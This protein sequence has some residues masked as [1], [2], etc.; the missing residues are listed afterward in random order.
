MIEV[1]IKKAIKAGN[2]SAVILPRAWLNKDVRVEL[3]KKTP[4][5]MLSDIINI[6]K[7]YISLKDIIGIYLTGSYARGEEEENSDIDI[8]VV[9]KG[10]DREMVK[11]GF[12]N[13]MIIS[14]ELL[15]QKLNLD[16]FPVG[17]MIKEAK[18]LINSDYL[19]S[20]QVKITKN[21]IK[22]YLDTTGEKLRIIKEIISRIEKKNKK[23]LSDKVAYTLVLR[24]RTLYIIKKLI[25]NAEYSKKDFVKIIKSISKGVNAYERYLAVKNNL[26]EENG[27]SIE[28]AGRLYEYLKNQLIEVKKLSK[29]LD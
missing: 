11:E 28:E 5:I 16:I 12:Y 20:I 9:T 10:I 19:Y 25:E 21:N 23:Y 13:I 7:K 22:W 3:A 4:E 29:T 18:P 26:E 27:I 15:K 6:S 24:I 1:Q 2:S 17:Q 14:S 8:L